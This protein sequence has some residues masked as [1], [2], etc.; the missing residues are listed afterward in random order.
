MLLPLR[1]SPEALL[2]AGTAVWF[3]LGVGSLVLLVRRQVSEARPA[4]LAAVNLP[5]DV[6]VL[7]LCG[8][9]PE[10]FLTVLTTVRLLLAVI[11]AAVNPL[12]FL[13]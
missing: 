4:W 12:V 10:T 5:V 9:S 6:C 11:L 3:L 2:T 1:Q 8:Q 7:L 13:L